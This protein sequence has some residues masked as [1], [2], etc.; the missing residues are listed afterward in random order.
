[1]KNYKT[2]LIY[3]ILIF[4]IVLLGTI[5]MYTGYQFMTNTT[6]LAIAGVKSFRYY[7]VDSNIIVGI[8]SLIMA[9]YEILVL[10]KKIDKIPLFV[11]L[12]KYIGV[13]G[14]SL[15]FIVTLL[16]LAPMY[17]SEF[18]YLYMNTNFLFHLVVPILAFISYV[19]YEKNDLDFKYSFVAIISM[20]IYS[21]FY[22]TNI[23]M[24]LDNGN[25]VKEY[26]W[27]GFVLGGISSIG[28]VIIIILVITYL[29]SY[30][31]YKLNKKN[32]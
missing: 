29:I 11:Y 7:T 9:I 2:S 10:N 14:V 30:L 28:F 3:N 25:V 5:F 21:I 26:D 15:T 31:I 12:L 22:T 18:L 13:V 6:L 27:Y 1:M 8:S 19:K 4:I 16:Y 32:K 20:I 24:H 23:L 17:G